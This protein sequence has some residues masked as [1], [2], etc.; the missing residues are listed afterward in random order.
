MIKVKKIFPSNQ[1]QN[2][3]ESRPVCGFGVTLLYS[4]SY[5]RFK[6]Y[7]IWAYLVWKQLKTANHQIIVL[8]KYRHGCS[9]K[10]STNL[11]FL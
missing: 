4:K 9:I 5:V 1:S 3:G 2:R 6:G 7:D 10:I 8:L 11:Y